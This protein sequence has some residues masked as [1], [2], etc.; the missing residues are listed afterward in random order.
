[1]NQIHGSALR[2]VVDHIGHIISAACKESGDPKR[3]GG[4]MCITDF[5]GNVQLLMLVGEIEDPRKAEMNQRLVLEKCQRLSDN[6]GHMS[7]A[8][9]AQ[10]ILGRHSGAIRGLTSLYGFSGLTPLLDEA[11][12]LAVA[13][14]AG[15]ISTKTIAEIIAASNNPHAKNLLPESVFMQPCLL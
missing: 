15:D 3:K 11:S 14:T 9:S 10:S 6:P 8:Q 5:D 4:Y 12:M 1:M 7:S 13:L 2:L